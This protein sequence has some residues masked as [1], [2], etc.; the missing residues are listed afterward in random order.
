MG[1]RRGKYRGKKNK[2]LPYCVSWNGKKLHAKYSENGETHSIGLYDTVSEAE[3]MA[4]LG[5]FG[6]HWI[7]MEEGPY[8]GFTYL[9]T[10]K[11]TG[12][13][14]VGLKR[15]YLWAGPV[16]GYKCYDMESEWWDAKAWKPNNWRE[17]TGSQKDLNAEIA[18]GNVWD[19]R[20]E[21]LDMCKTVLDLHMSEVWH[22]VEWNVLEATDKNGDYLWYNKNIAGL[23]YRA[24]FR[25]CDVIEA[26]AETMEAM[27]D[28][29][30]KPN[31]DIKGKVIPFGQSTKVVS[32]E[33]RG[34][35]DVR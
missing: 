10:N 22:M 2:E 3:Y 18:R 7:G 20:Y 19:F 35:K 31:L 24:P 16:G 25:R 23:E 11:V 30:L 6:H 34:F 17:Y 28:Y 8:F 1:K 9:I 29:Y 13:R 21:V 5:R 32:L 33:T 12:K 27:R 15:F 4:I 14:Y 26:Q